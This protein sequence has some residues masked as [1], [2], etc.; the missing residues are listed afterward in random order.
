MLIDILDTMDWK[1]QME[2][3]APK[4]KTKDIT[5][6]LAWFWK[7]TLLAAALTLGSLSPVGL[8]SS[9]WG[10]SPSDYVEPVTPPT[11]AKNTPP[12]IET[13]LTE[14][15]VTWGHELRISGNQL[16]IGTHLVA[17][18]SD[19]ET[20]TC[21]VKLTLDGKE[22]KAGTSLTDEGTLILTVT[23]GSGESKSITVKL[24]ITNGAPEIKLELSELNV[25]AGAEVSIADNKLLIGGEVV[26]SWTDDRTEQC[27]VKL[28]LDGKDVKAGDMLAE[29]GT[30]TLTVTD[31]EE[32][33]ASIDVTLTNDSI[34]GMEALNSL[35]LQ[36]DAE[37]DLLN[38]ISFA[39]G[40]E[41]VKVEVE[42]DGQR[43]EITEP[44]LYT[45]D[46]AWT[47]TVIFTVKGK[48]GNTAEVKSGNLSIKALEY[49]ALSITNI[50]PVDILPIIGQIDEWDEH[51]YDHIEHLR[52]AE[53]T[54]I[55]DMMWEYGTGKHTS[56]E[57][58]ELM[59]RLNTWMRWEMPLW[60][61]NYEI[62]GIQ[63]YAQPNN[64]AH[65]EW[66]I[67]NSIIKYANFKLLMWDFEKSR[68]Q[69]MIDYMKDH[70]NSINIFGSSTY[71]NVDTKQ[72]YEEQ[73]FK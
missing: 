23:D 21:E 45:P 5:I 29:A 71:A 63:W 24:K 69:T 48:V 64:H 54:R 46:Y 60:Y 36:V 51:A 68:E 20:T 41:L 66:S 52:V 31:A 59:G 14:I 30:L 25:F 57:Y 55:R 2:L 3:K 22:V 4:L 43:Y 56:E 37:A 38:G 28:T 62:L 9:C 72:K 6:R 50:S 47:C 40:I 18:W 19:K 33:S 65:V 44:Y 49:K 17:S 35:N 70:P 8:L 42:K 61:N 26:A 73:I 11:P 53:A 27:E 10:D 12:T 13:K 58:Q 34:Y 1:T 16:Y 15:D 7:N 32:K 67:L 39:E